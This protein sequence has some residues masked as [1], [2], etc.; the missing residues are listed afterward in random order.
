MGSLAAF[1]PDVGTSLANA[2]DRLDEAQS[3]TD[4]AASAAAGRAKDRAE[5]LD[6]LADEADR[7]APSAERVGAELALQASYNAAVGALEEAQRRLDAATA[8]AKS[9]LRLA[10]SH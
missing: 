1:S 2:A 4:I 9:S 7:V 10:S 6:N 8:S 5:E 3:N